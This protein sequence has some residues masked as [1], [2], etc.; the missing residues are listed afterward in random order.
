VFARDGWNWVGLGLHGEHVGSL[1]S[2]GGMRHRPLSRIERGRD[3]ACSPL[4]ARR[5]A[6]RRGGDREKSIVRFLFLCYYLG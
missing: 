4:R 5:G 2:D 1:S 3:G 6:M